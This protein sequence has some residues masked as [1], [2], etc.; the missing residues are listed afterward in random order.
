M[1]YFLSEK[2]CDAFVQPAFFLVGNRA[3]NGVAIVVAFKTLFTLGSCFRSKKEKEN[4]SE[5]SSSLLVFIQ[6]QTAR[7]ASL[8]LGKIPKWLVGR[9]I[10]GIELK[11]GRLFR[12]FLLKAHYYPAYY[13]QCNGRLT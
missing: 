10:L 8:A 7:T 9:V 4:D 13:I 6:L 1:L 5:T 11:Y 3:R 12:K 2:S